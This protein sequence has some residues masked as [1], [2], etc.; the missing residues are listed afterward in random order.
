MTEERIW[1]FIALG[2]LPEKEKG[3]FY[4]LI[5][6]D[7][8]AEGAFLIGSD[9]SYFENPT[10]RVG[11]LMN[12]GS[13]TS[14]EGY[15]TS[16][17]PVKFSINVYLEKYYVFSMPGR[18]FKLHFAV[19]SRHLFAGSSG[20]KEIAHSFVVEGVEKDYV[21]YLGEPVFSNL[22]SE[23][24][25]SIDLAVNF[26]SDKRTDS[27]LSFID[28]ENI[29]KGVKLINTYNPIYGSVVGYIKSISKSL[30][31][32][33]RNKTITNTHITFSTNPGPTSIPLIEGTYILIQPKK[34]ED[35][36]FNHLKYDLTKGTVIN[37]D[38]NIL[39]RNHMIL[40]TEM[41]SPNI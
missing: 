8:P 24:I 3:E 5:A 22:S 32:S 16:Q 17:V 11:I 2:N 7:E 6:E 12:D 34:D 30:L 36:D 28:N 20:K 13:I 15:A 25:F 9:S 33:K 21:N 14:A 23:R 19:G 41:T 38:Q 37:N 31:E 26:V 39:E 18:R 29:K 10:L 40:R 27:L 35:L 1:D 4:D